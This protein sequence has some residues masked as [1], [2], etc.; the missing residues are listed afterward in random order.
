[1]IDHGID[2]NINMMMFSMFLLNMVC[3]VFVEY[4]GQVRDI[5]GENWVTLN[6]GAVVTV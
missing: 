3:Y 5:K 2:N 6:F 4:G 1:M